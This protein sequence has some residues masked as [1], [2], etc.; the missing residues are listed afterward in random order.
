MLADAVADVPE[1]TPNCVDDW[2][3]VSPE[4][5]DKRKD[6]FGLARH[7]AVMAYARWYDYRHSGANWVHRKSFS[8]Q[9]KY[10]LI[11]LIFHP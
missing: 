7:T 8:H 4:G 10:T 3:N 9:V 11:G 2:S 5:A 6:E 1:L